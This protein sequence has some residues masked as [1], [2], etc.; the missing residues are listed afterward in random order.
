MHLI[1]YSIIAFFATVAPVF[2]DDDPVL[3][4][5]ASAKLQLERQIVYCQGQSQRSITRFDLWLNS[6]SEFVRKI[7]I[8]RLWVDANAACTSV[9]DDAYSAALVEYSAATGDQKELMEWLQLHPRKALRPVA[10][11]PPEVLDASYHLHRLSQYS[12]FKHPFDLL[13]YFAEPFSSQI[14][15][16]MMPPSKDIFRQPITQSTK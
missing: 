15:S 13:S 7:L 11:L 1:K 16:A 10:S 6:Q 9:A 3:K 5:L 8:Y 2:G 14:Q 4:R 12:D